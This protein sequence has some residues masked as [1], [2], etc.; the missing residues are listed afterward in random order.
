MKM[1]L[2]YRHHLLY[3]RFHSHFPAWHKYHCSIFTIILILGFRCLFITRFDLML[4]SADFA[5]SHIFLYS[6]ISLFHW[7]WEHLLG[8]RLRA[9]FIGSGLIMLA[10]YADTI[11][12]VYYWLTSRYTWFIYHYNRQAD[13]SATIRANAFILYYTLYLHLMLIAWFHLYYAYLRARHHNDVYFI[14]R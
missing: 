7:Y 5:Q 13:E 8:F 10:S 3:F 4:I 1:Y 2:P 6:F 9:Y 12:Q 14:S 11:Y